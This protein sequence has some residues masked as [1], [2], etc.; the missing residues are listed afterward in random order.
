MTETTI[1]AGLLGPRF[2]LITEETLVRR[3]SRSPPTWRN[4]TQI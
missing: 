4:Y 1:H 3:A 2:E